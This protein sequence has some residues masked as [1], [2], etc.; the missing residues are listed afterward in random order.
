LRSPFRKAK[1]RYRLQ[2]PV[3]N[4]DDDDDDDDDDNNNERN[5]EAE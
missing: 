5:L 3:E 4:N 2:K 1:F